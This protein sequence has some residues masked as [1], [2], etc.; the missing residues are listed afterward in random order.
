MQALGKCDGRV[1]DVHHDPRSQG[2]REVRAVWCTVEAL[3]AMPVDLQFT[4][5]LIVG[6]AAT[7]QVE[8]YWR[9]GVI[10]TVH[11]SLDWSQVQ[12]GSVSGGPFPQV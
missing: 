5:L 1:N 6:A 12:C 7:A 2:L 11:Y 3:A 10:P 9:E 4:C 8:Y